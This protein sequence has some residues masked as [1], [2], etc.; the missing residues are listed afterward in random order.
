M[1]ATDRVWINRPIRHDNA[2]TRAGVIE[3]AADD[4]AVVL[5]D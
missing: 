1:T 4:Q 5:E 2:R 3:Q